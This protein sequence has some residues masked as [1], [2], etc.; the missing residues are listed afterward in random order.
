MNELKQK[1]SDL[2]LELETC[3]KNAITAEQNR[4]AELNA[5][6]ELARTYSEAVDLLKL[7]LK[8]LKTES[9]HKL[10]SEPQDKVANKPTD[11]EDSV[12]DGIEQGVEEGVPEEYDDKSR[13]DKGDEDIYEGEEEE[14]E[15]EEEEGEY[16][17]EEGEEVGTHSSHY[18]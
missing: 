8:P 18:M 17:E 12:E 1:I 2:T 3:K 9:G 16:E 7:Q 15:Y 6:M 13:V 10:L 11:I 5:L 4:R 14:G